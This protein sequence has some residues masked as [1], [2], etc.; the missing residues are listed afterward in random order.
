MSKLAHS[1]QETMDEIDYRA[2]IENGDEDL[3]P[4]SIKISKRWEAV[5]PW[6]RWFGFDNKEWGPILV[7]ANALFV[8]IFIISI[9]EGKPW[10]QPFQIFSWAICTVLLYLI[11]VI[12][13]QDRWGI[14]LPAIK[15]P[16]R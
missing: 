1:N 10:Y 6:K 5:R 7:A 12:A 8:G 9:A 15:R 11:V 14:T 16:K 3:I 13:I 2:A 4:A